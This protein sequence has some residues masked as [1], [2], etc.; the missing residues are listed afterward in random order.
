V[1]FLPDKEAVS[2]EVAFTAE[3]LH[4]L[5]REPGVQAIHWDEEVGVGKEANVAEAEDHI[6]WAN[7][8]ART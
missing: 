6:L 8:E 3:T 5:F 2:G 4:H 7:I 1:T